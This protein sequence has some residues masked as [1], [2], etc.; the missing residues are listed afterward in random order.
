M[1][2]KSDNLGYLNDQKREIFRDFAPW[3]P[4]RGLPWTRWGGSEHTTK[5]P[6]LRCS[7]RLL[8]S[9]LCIYFFLDSCFACGGISVKQVRVQKSNLATVWLDIVDAYGSIPYKLIVFALHRM[10][11]LHSGSELLK[12]TTRG[13]SVYH[14]LNQQLV[15]GIDINREFLLAPF[16]L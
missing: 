2:S 3:T 12:H 5:S 13:F 11:S 16:F 7:H 1:H 15:L 10:V 8:R 6:A 4:T 9:L 14:F